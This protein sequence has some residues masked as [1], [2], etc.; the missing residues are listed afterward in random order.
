MNQLRWLLCLE[1]FALAGCAETYPGG[2][3]KTSDQ[4]ISMAQRACPDAWKNVPGP[5][6]AKLEEGVGGTSWFVWK[7]KDYRVQVNI[8]AAS[9]Q[10][11]DEC[12]FPG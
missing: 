12:T 6:H 10:G 9:G 3:V 11:A 5:W 8:D 7:G 1:L 2:I 4:A